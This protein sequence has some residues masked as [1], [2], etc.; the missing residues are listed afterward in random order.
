MTLHALKPVRRG[1]LRPF[2]PLAVLL[3]AVAAQDPKQ[4][5]KPSA[6]TH[7]SPAAV[8]AAKKVF[9]NYCSTCHGAAGLGDGAAAAALNPKPRT[10]TDAKWQ[11]SVSDEHLQKVI[12]EGGAAVKLSPLMAPAK[13]M[14]DSEPAGTIDAMVALVRELGKPAAIPAEATKAAETIYTNYCSTC[15][16]PK[17]AGD[18]AAAAALNPKPRTFADAAWQRSVSSDHIAKVIQEGGAAV[19]KS[20][21]MAPAKA[22]FTGQPEATLDA[23]VQIVRRLGREAAAEKPKAEAA[24]EKK[25]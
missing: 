9:A 7:P 6:V 14:I 1:A 3:V 13:A 8:A 17:G 23:M 20:P 2:A 25:G 12:L 24:P 18:G 16:G 21:L 5:P 15:H 4:D 10:F 22:M 19:G 11:N